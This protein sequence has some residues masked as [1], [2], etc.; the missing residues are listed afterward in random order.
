MLVVFVVEVELEEVVEFV[1]V[2]L[3]EEG[4]GVGGTVHPA[5]G[6]AA[7]SQVLSKRQVAVGVL[8]DRKTDRSVQ[9]LRSHNA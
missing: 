4:G 2:V 1:V 5:E 6:N 9:L 8:S 7:T 3:V